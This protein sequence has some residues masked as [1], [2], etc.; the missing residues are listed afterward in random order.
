MLYDRLAI[1]NVIILVETIIPCSVTSCM[2][3]WYLHQLKNGSSSED[4]QKMEDTSAISAG[5]LLTPFNSYELVFISVSLVLTIMT[6][7]LHVTTVVC[8]FVMPLLRL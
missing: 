8:L 1:N 5:L 2:T 6:Q 7:Q 4:V 3:I